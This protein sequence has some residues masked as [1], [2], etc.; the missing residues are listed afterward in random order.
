M[1]MHAT[2]VR[3]ALQ[4]VTGTKLSLMKP[5]V[6]YNTTRRFATVID[7]SDFSYLSHFENVDD[8][9]YRAYLELSG[10][11]SKYG[12]GHSIENRFG[13]VAQVEEY[14]DKT[15]EFQVFLTTTDD[16]VEISN[17]ASEMFNAPELDSCDALDMELYAKYMA[18]VDYTEQIVDMLRPF[19]S[20]S[21]VSKD[22][23]REYIALKQIPKYSEF[24]KGRYDEFKVSPKAD[25]GQS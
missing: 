19:A 18:L 4:T 3:A 14:L 12:H 7:T 24:L 20:A 23:L 17:K 6:K 21:N 2:H 5:I 9:A 10:C 11:R 8:D 13:G 1:E 16:P 15:A 22:A 25:N